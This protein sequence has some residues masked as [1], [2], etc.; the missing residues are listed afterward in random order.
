MRVALIDHYDSF[1]FNVLEW[2]AATGECDVVHVPFDDPE[3]IAAVVDARL[4]LVLSPGPRAPADVPTTLALAHTQLGRVPILGVCL[5]HQILGAL[6]GAQ[7]VPAR[8]PWHGTTRTIVPSDATSPLAPLGPF[9]A[10][11]YNSLVLDAATLPAPWRVIARCA[12]QGDVQAIARIVPGEAPALGVQ[13]HP[14]SFL[15]ERKGELARV[16]L[17]LASSSSSAGAYAS[18]AAEA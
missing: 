17:A 4:P 5:G 1:T 11:I 15:S 14:E 16:F 7:I 12:E 2:L 18:S 3:A 6:A 10:A 9:R 8:A 13:F